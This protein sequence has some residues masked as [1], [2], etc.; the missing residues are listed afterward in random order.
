MDLTRAFP[1]PDGE[2]ITRVE[3]DG[4][5]SFTDFGL[6]LEPFT[7]IA[8]VNGVGKSN[9]F[10]ALRHI[11]RLVGGGVHRGLPT[12]RS[13]FESNRGS[14]HD[15]FTWHP[16]GSRAHR[17]RFALELV[18][19][20]SIRDPY[21]VDKPLVHR[22]VRYEVVVGVQAD[23]PRL[24]F[25]R[26]RPIARHD[27]T[28]LRRHDALRATVPSA[29]GGKRPDFIGTEEDRIVVSQD[30]RGGR[31][32]PIP[33]SATTSTALSSISDVTFPHAYAT[34]RALTDLHFV[35]LEPEA[36]RAPSALAAPAT[37]G[38]DGSGLPAALARI[39][40]DAPEALR[41]LSATVARIVPGL[42]HV[43][44]DRDDVREEYSLTTEYADGHALPA[45]LVSDGT[46][47]LIALATL[48]HDPNVVGTV[49][50]EEPENGIYAGRVPEL[51]DLLH[52]FVRTP[53]ARGRERQLLANTHSVPLV[54]AMR[55][56]GLTESLLFAS[57]KR[58]VRRDRPVHRATIMA[59][60]DPEG[61]QERLFHEGE[62][63]RRRVAY[64]EMERLLQATVA[65]EAQ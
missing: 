21:A 42:V 48:V 57:L 25:E 24:V 13:A 54:K 1:Y 8:G 44:V 65:S 19:P 61:V 31:K 2:M 49:I 18:L 59:A 56:R 22:R 52:T 11:Q 16:D 7:V 6:D 62:E 5:K 17:M 55:E 41:S 3:I 51:L 29:P 39:S 43:R 64:Q 4:F 45:R 40:R 46:L 10:D 34:K 15:L 33:L 36:L 14:L 23:T 37:L 28:F 26:L 63:D 20:E 32:H 53:H 12:L 30:Q 35:Q 38:P 27:D 9:L 58:V 60:V 47:R 50:L